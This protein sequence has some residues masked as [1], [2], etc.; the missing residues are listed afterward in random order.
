VKVTLFPLGS[1]A[2]SP[3]GVTATCATEKWVS[4]W[5]VKHANTMVVPCSKKD[6]FEAA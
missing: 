6:V 5:K 3:L 1:S 2:P 4:A